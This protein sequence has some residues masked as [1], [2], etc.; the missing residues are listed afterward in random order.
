MGQLTSEN[1]TNE[2]QKS[3]QHII[4]ARLASAYCSTFVCIQNVVKKTEQTVTDVLQKREFYLYGRPRFRYAFNFNCAF[5]Q[6]DNLLYD[7]QSQ[8]RSF[9]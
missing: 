4:F 1:K 5:V 6:F 3:Q 8:T 7:G 2:R 9:Q